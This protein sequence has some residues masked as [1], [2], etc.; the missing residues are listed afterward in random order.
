MAMLTRSHT[1]QEATRFLEEGQFPPGSMGPKVRAA[2]EFLEG[3]GREVIVTDEKTMEAALE[4]QGGT[5][6]LHE[7]MAED[8]GGQQVLFW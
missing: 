2:V 5:T 3:G 4:G 1:T 8:W 6:I 7:G